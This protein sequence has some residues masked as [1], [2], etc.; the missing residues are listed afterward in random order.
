MLYH[1][2]TDMAIIGEEHLVTKDFI[3]A[4]GSFLLVAL[5]GVLIGILTAIITG[6]TT[7]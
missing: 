7:K 5:G 1:A 2:L 3:L 6:L 4:S